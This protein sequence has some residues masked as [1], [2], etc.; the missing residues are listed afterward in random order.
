[1]F[2]GPEEQDNKVCDGATERD[3]HKQVSQR[4]QCEMFN[5]QCLD[6][7][8]VSTPVFRELHWHRIGD[9]WYD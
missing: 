1:M 7:E 8:R 5:C 2:C 9:I 6:N 4:F 3:F